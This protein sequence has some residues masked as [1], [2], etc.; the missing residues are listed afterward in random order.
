VPALAPDSALES[1]LGLLPV[2]PCLSLSLLVLLTQL[3]WLW[4]LLLL[5]LLVLAIG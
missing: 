1:Q 3:P 4:K 5:S 2:S